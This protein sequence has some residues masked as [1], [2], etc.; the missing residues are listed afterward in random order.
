MVLDWLFSSHSAANSIVHP[1]IPEP[2]PP[3]DLSYETFRVMLMK[4]TD[5]PFLND[6]WDYPTRSASAPEVVYSDHMH[7]IPLFSSKDQIISSTGKCIGK[8]NFSKSIHP[9]LLTVDPDTS[10]VTRPIG[11]PVISHATPIESYKCADDMMPVGFRIGG[12]GPG[13]AEMSSV[14]GSRTYQELGPHYLGR[15]FKDG[16]VCVEPSAVE[17]RE[18]IVKEIRAE[19]VEPDGIITVENILKSLVFN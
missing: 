5:A 8:L 14:G 11:G 4:Q 17:A 15:I 3:G 18:M 6:Y 9:E 7:H 2:T 10:L 1:P 19:G 13:S 16:S 12:G